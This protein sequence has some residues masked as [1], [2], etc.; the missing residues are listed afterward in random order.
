MR[1]FLF[2]LSIIVIATS[3]TKSTNNPQ[4]VVAAPLSVSYAFSASQ[5]DTYTIS[6]T[7]TNKKVT[8]EVVTGNT[9]SKNLKIA[10]S[11]SSVKLTLNVESSNKS[12]DATGNISVM[13]TGQMPSS[14]PL[15]SAADTYGLRGQITYYT[16]TP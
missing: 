2:F 3:C 10:A 12:F 13:V 4:P 16:S 6:Y 5:N 14:M 1:K 7:D 9:W 11:T 15:R 8:T